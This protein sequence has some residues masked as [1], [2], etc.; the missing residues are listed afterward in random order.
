M[1]QDIRHLHS[2]FQLAIVEL[3]LHSQQQDSK[4][5]SYDA[6]LSEILNLFK[7]SKVSAAVKNNLNS[8]ARANQPEQLHP[9]GGSDGAAVM[10]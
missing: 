3:K 9:T 4:H 8:S 6:T 5:S 2:S 10:G 7:Q 1:E